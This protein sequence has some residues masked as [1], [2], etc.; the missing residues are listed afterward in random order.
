[1]K[2][3]KQ[4]DFLVS[5]WGYEQTNVCFYQVVSRTPSTV[6]LQEVGS[7]KQRSTQYITDDMTYAAVPNP[8]EKVKQ[9]FRRKV[10]KTTWRGADNEEFVRIESYEHA[11]IWEKRPVYGTDYH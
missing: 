4:G 11:R 8:D 6:T 3:I 7:R 10:H 2:T 1:M 5:R 9:P